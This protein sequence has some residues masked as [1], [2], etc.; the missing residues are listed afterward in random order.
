MITPSAG[1]FI[2]IPFLRPCTIAP[3]LNYQS[4][5]GAFTYHFAGNIKESYTLK[6]DFVSA[7]LPVFF[8]MPVSDRVKPYLF[9]SPD[10]GFAIKGEIQ[11]T[12]PDHNLTDYAVAINPSNF[13]YAYFGALGGLGIRFNFPLSLITIVVKADAAVNW[14]FRDTFS[15]HEHEGVA[16][17]DNVHSYTLQG[18]RFSR[19]LEIHLSFGFFINKYDACGSFSK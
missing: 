4:R 2:E 6:A 9:L 8:Y 12:H 13:K 15:K 7:R 3:E 1:F 16:I 17:P 11:L 19:G 5:G 10:I 14:G 18:K